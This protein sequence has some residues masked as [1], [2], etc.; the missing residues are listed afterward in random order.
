MSDKDL[1]HLMRLLKDYSTKWETIGLSLGFIQP[2]L[3]I[4]SGMSKLLVE[5]P[6]SYLRELLSQWIQW[7][8][9]KHQ[10]NPTLEALYT[11]LRS[12][13]VGLGALAEEVKKEM[14]HCAT[15]KKNTPK[16]H[17]NFCHLPSV[18]LPSPGI[19]FCCIV[20]VCTMY[21]YLSVAKVNCI[22]I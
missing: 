18:F 1:F 13:L 10:N 9:E 2:E 12:D 17:S 21:M 5:A 15:G 22:L 8:T 19:K 7:P 16:F 14:K 11:A 3:N 6:V 20:C 4:I